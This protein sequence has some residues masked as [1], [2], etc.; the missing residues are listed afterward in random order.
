MIHLQG[1]ASSGT[2][3]FESNW[4]ALSSSLKRIHTKDASELS[5][6][7]LYRNSYNI[8]LIHRGDE[9]YEQ[10]VQLEK[11][12]LCDE[13]QKRVVAGISPSLL[14]AK[15]VVDIQD[16][17]TERR[18]AGEKFLSV[19]K[20]VWEDHQLCMQMITDVLMYMVRTMR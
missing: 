19:L 16:Q 2:D 5:F 17:A 15:A 10:T 13:I 4:K 11:E 8:V 3:A 12:W 1:L 7:Q 20:E 14:L 9:L 6:E 18:V